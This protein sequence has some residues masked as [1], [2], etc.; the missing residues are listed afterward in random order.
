MA[1]AESTL[2]IYSTVHPEPS[3][4]G[5]SLDDDNTEYVAQPPSPLLRTPHCARSSASSFFSFSSCL[6]M[7]GLQGYGRPALDRASARP[8]ASRVLASLQGRDAGMRLK[9]NGRFCDGKQK[10]LI[11]SF[12]VT[13]NCKSGR[14]LPCHENISECFFASNS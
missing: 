2:Y 1:C 13:I 8:P 4:T 11:S 5:V 10:R 9:K 14:V 12:T 6:S 7:V 3:Q